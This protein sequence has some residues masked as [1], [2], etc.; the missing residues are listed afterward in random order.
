MIQDIYK[1]QE[2][3]MEM[4]IKKVRCKMKSRKLN[5]F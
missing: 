2:S 4:E 1:C 3:Q 5:D